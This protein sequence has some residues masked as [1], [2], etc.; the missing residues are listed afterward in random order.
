MHAFRNMLIICYWQNYPTHSNAPADI[1][2]AIFL[3]A[4]D[5]V[6]CCETRQPVLFGNNINV[7]EEFG[8]DELTPANRAQPITICP[9][10]AFTARMLINPLTP[11]IMGTA[12][13]HPAPD[14]VKP[15]ICNF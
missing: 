9:H 11:T 10:Y 7:L 1:C 3:H 4:R 14:R 6:V 15:V 8:V 12:I 13:K 2:I 5:L